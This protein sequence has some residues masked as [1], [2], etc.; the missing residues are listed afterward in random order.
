MSV[1]PSKIEPLGGEAGLPAGYKLCKYLESTG[2]QWID[3]E[4]KPNNHTQI[5][6]RCYWVQKNIS[7]IC[8]C[9]TDW[10]TSGR[11]VSAGSVWNG[12]CVMT[13]YICNKDYMLAPISAGVWVYS[14]MNMNGKSVISTEDGVYKEAPFDAESGGNFQLSITLPLF[15]GRSSWSLYNIAKGRCSSLLVMEYDKPVL[16]L[17]PA[18]DKASIPCMFDTVRGKSFYNKGSGQ[19]LYKLA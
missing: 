12:G 17:V 14:A 15:R 10:N 6:I 16:N 1:V 7:D 13:S 8:T 9:Y 18:L 19:F 2:T 3:T 11:G 5:G 4:Y